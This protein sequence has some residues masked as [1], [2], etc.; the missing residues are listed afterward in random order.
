M[1]AQGGG[2]LKNVGSRLVAQHRNVKRARVKERG[3]FYSCCDASFSRMTIL[4]AGKIFCIK[5]PLRN[6]NFT[7]PSRAE[8][9]LVGRASCWRT[10]DKGNRT[11]PAPLLRFGSA[12]LTHECSRNGW[13]GDRSLSKANGRKWA[14]IREGGKDNG[15]TECG[16]NTSA[17]QR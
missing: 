12:S 17:H 2:Y 7:S 6:A 10:G 5:R 1:T 16:R 15:S 8:T 3:I 4:L 11:K 14:E 13:R 9:R